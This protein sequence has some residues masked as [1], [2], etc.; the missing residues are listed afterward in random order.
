MNINFILKVVVGEQQHIQ[1]DNIVNIQWPHF[2]EI[3]D[4]TVVRIASNDQRSVEI[5]NIVLVSL[6]Q[7]IDCSFNGDE[8]LVVGISI[9]VNQS[10]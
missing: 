3:I 1:T 8:A 10:V 4:L 6:L 9:C 5:K 2:F 7:N